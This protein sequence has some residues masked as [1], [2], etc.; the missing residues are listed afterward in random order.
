MPPPHD[1]AERG[2]NLVIGLVNMMPNAALATSLQFRRLL[3]PSG[4]K[5]RVFAPTG[6]GQGH[7]SIDALW[8]AEL[9]GIIVTG[10]EPL[11]ACMSRE[12]AWPLLQTLVDWAADH[13][14]AAVWSCLAAHAAVYRLDGL[15]RQPLAAKLSGIFPCQKLSPHPVLQAMPPRWLVPHS[16]RNGL[17]E[18]ALRDA[19]YTILSGSPAVGVDS[20]LKPHGRSLFLFLQGH[21]EYGATTLQGE[22]RRDLK[23]FAAGDAAEPP[24][25]PAGATLAAGAAPPWESPARALYAGWLNAVTARQASPG[26]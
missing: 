11:A 23:R 4:A 18:E 9:D 21:P 5:L 8:A 10:C 16:R 7:E 6:A 14:A 13:V 22:Y 3:R 26:T 25:P 12:P 15:Q 17:R 1:P 24:Q 2:G 20:F 19:G